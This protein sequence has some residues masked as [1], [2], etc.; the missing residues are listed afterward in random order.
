[1]AEGVTIMCADYDFYTNFNL[2]HAVLL[3][4]VAIL[5]G[6]K[7]RF[8]VSIDGKKVYIKFLQGMIGLSITEKWEPDIEL[9]QSGLFHLNGACR[10]GTIY[11]HRVTEVPA[12][13]SNHMPNKV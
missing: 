9:Q 6:W 3:V 13:I 8:I 7:Y 5:I 12:G 4:V 1:M 10:L 11:Q 2:K